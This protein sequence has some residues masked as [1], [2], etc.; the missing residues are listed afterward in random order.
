MVLLLRYRVDIKEV[1]CKS[2][3]RSFDFALHPGDE[4]L[5]LGT[6]ARSAQDDRFVVVSSFLGQGN[7]IAKDTSEAYK[8]Q[9]RPELVRAGLVFH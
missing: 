4:D 9:P 8:H 1:W 6:P 7:G 5:S 3:R 2:N